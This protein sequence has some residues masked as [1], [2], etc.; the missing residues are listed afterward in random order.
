[1]MIRLNRKLKIFAALAA[2]TSLGAPVAAHEWHDRDR[3]DDH[4][5]RSYP[6]YDD[7]VHLRG[8]GVEDLDPWLRKAKSGRK[9]VIRVLGTNRVSERGAWIANREF[10]RVR[11]DRDRDWD[12]GDRYSD[13]GRPWDN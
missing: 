13:R 8:S 5:R 6:Q 10:A 7:Y 3:Y 4:D 2:L 12:R 1:M 9:F 11:H